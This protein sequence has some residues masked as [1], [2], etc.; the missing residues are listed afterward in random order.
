MEAEKY[1]NRCGEYFL[2]DVISTSCYKIALKAGENGVPEI[3]YMFGKQ[4]C[5]TYEILPFGDVKQI[6]HLNEKYTLP[7]IL[8]P[9]GETQTQNV[10]QL[11]CFPIKSGH[12]AW[13]KESNYGIAFYKKLGEIYGKQVR[14]ENVKDGIVTLELEV[15]EPML[16]GDFRKCGRDE[17]PRWNNLKL[18]K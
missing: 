6:S 10:Y 16:Y 18:S 17:I 2:Y 4:I 1:K 5:V 13:Y 3:G 15:N 9:F 8:K 12:F 11:I 14:K 7:F